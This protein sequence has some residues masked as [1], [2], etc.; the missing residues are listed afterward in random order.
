MTDDAGMED[1]VKKVY[2][3]PLHLGIFVLI[4]SK[5]FGNN[6][7]HALKGFYTIDVYYRD[8]DQLYLKNKHWE[9]LDKAGL[10]GKNT[11]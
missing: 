7:I 6:F 3:M 11:R 8:T 1:E 2:T 4:N 9:K 10:F 5:R